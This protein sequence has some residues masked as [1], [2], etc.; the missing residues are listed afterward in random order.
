[1][2]MSDIITFFSVH[3]A[4][5]FCL[6]L[7]IVI[8]RNTRRSEVRKAFL[9]TDLAM[10]IWNVGTM[11]EMDVRLLTETTNMLF[12]K[13]C[14]VSI[15][16]VPVVVLYLG[17]TIYLPAWRPTPG[18]LAMLV[19]PFTSIIMVFTNDSHHLFFER[20]S[21]YSA[22]AT[23]GV[24]YYFHSM[25]SY[26]CIFVG[27]AY[28]FFC[29]VKN[30]GIFSK[31]SGLVLLGTLVPVIGN[32]LFSFNIAAL[33]FEINAA[34]FTITIL[35]FYIAFFK[36]RFITALPITVRQVVDL[37]S[38]G[39]L[40]VDP[41]L[42][43]IDYN[44]SLLHFLS[45]PE[46]MAKDMTLREFLSACNAEGAYDDILALH[47]QSVAEMRT[48][49]IEPR[50]GDDMFV[51]I[52]ITP[53]FQDNEQI[54]SILLLRDVTQIN[55]A[56]ETIKE[57]QT[58]L[59]GRE[60]MVSLGQIAAGIAHNLRTP[61]LS[62]AGA[63]V[64][65]RGLAQE[66]GDS[67]ADPSVT[68]DDHREISA[69]MQQWIDKAEVHCDYISDMIA[70]V[71]GQAVQLNS[72]EAGSFPIGEFWKR[73]DML[74]KHELKLGNCELLVSG[75]V[76]MQ[77]EIEGDVNSF[78]QIFDN[79]IIN[80]IHAYE[81]RP[82]EICISIDRQDRFYVFRV[83]DS[84]AGIAP[85]IRERLFKEMVTT[86][87]KLGTGLGLYLSYSTIKGLFN[88]QMSVESEQGKGTV[89]TILIPV[90]EDERRLNHA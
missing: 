64:A 56:M 79:L 84:G 74:M 70:T 43:I 3:I 35:C 5:I 76:D 85:E 52:E 17:R 4:F 42:R 25:Y 13:I 21:L 82:G 51:D 34:L 78:V 12:I 41:Q 47:A 71:K 80:A 62:I 49:K 45:D 57:N 30:T 39:Y 33:S 68:P 67:I 20:F 40:V 81:G 28:I 1:M 53:I 6:V 31:Q 37:I 87:G 61:L 65:V 22:D 75:N 48:V 16:I 90:P 32:I 44:K 27:L 77:A 10:L 15:C 60:R 86:K 63:L 50:F 38:D 11:L 46:N 83:A 72:G 73:V 2:K 18:F 66:Y 69:E 19:V 9:V 89:F 14:Y 29:S 8:W 7:V 36:Y 88:G 55:R 24:Y 54:G 59:I 26:G 23:Y 58:I